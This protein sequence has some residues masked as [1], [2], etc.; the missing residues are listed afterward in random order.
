MFF[1]SFSVFICL[2]GRSGFFG[3]FTYFSVFFIFSLF[4][5]NGP[6][7]TKRFF[8]SE[9]SVWWFFGS[10]LFLIF[11][12]SFFVFLGRRARRTKNI[13]S[14]NYFPVWGV[15]LGAL[16]DPVFFFVSSFC[17]SAEQ[18]GEKQF[19]NMR[20]LPY[21]YMYYFYYLVVFF[22]VFFCVG[23]GSGFFSGSS[24]CF[25]LFLAAEQATKSFCEKQRYKCIYIYVVGLICWPSLGH[26]S[27]KMLARVT[28]KCWPR[29]FRP[30]KEGFEAFF[31]C[32]FRSMFGPFWGSIFPWHMLLLLLKILHFGGV[33]L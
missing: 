22:S 1:V 28:L 24:F 23:D 7:R 27:V 2:G 9:G 17:F 12:F 15:G 31:F 11:S 19:C 13:C 16:P 20:A 14:V 25:S 32:F 8:L 33:S 26:F 21:T 30:I 5:L 6:G 4:L 29:S 3:V 10:M 18:A